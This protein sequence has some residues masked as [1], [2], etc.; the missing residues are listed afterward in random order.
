MPTGPPREGSEMR[1]LGSVSVIPYGVKVAT[2]P[3]GP[4]GE[5]G[6]MGPPVPGF[7]APSGEKGATGSPGE[8]GSFGPAGPPG[9]KGPMG[10]PGP[11]FAGPPGEK[12]AIGPA[13]PPG[14][15]GPMGPSGPPGEKEAIGPAGPPGEKGPMGPPGPGFVAPPGEKGPM[16]PPGPGFPG[17]PG[18]K[19]PTG[20]KGAMGPPGKK[21]A[22]GPPGREMVG[23]PGEKG[24]MGP[25]GERG[26]M[27]CPG[28]KG[29]IG[30]PGRKGAI[31]PPGRKGA[32]G[33]TGSAG[34][35]A[36]CPSGYNMFQ[37]TCYKMFST[38]K[39]FNQAAS[40]CNEDGG[41]LAMPQDAGTNTFLVSLQA[42]KVYWIG[43]HDQRKE[44]RFQWM[45]GSDIGKYNSWYPKQPDNVYGI[46]D[47]VLSFDGK[48]YDMECRNRMLFSCEV[49]PNST[50]ISDHVPFIKSQVIQI[51]CAKLNRND[52]WEL[53]KS[54]L[55]LIRKEAGEGGLEGGG[56]GDPRKS[57]AWSRDLVRLGYSVIKTY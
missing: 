14:E 48:W 40:A 32:T 29:A 51:Q 35:P 50:Y 7:T 21:G 11:G 24:A 39:K 18:E 13:G 38:P 16:G 42:K 55:P 25:P 27:G 6:P 23:P 12:G 4:P 52:G 28:E 15:K 22:M 20:E 57:R 53:P 37:Q 5:K 31:G 33:P 43:L 9:E 2:G 3:S 1:P 45:D 54:Y 49:A 17:P 56:L 47:C 10:P 19:G 44:G 30:P 36:R 46:E 41:T 8:M 34:P 26:V